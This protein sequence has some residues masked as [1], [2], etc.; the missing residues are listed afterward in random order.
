MENTIILLFASMNTEPSHAALQRYIFHV[1]Q[2]QVLISQSLKDIKPAH[3]LFVLTES[4]AVE[5]GLLNHFYKNPE[6]LVVR[7]S[8]LDQ[9]GIS[10]LDL[11]NLK[12]H[13]SMAMKDPNSIG[14]H[15]Y[16]SKE[17]ITALKPF[18]RSHG[19]NSAI[20]SLNYMKYYLQNGIRL[21]QSQDIDWTTAYNNFLSMALKSWLEYK[22]KF[23]YFRPHFELLQL[24]NQCDLLLKMNDTIDLFINGKNYFRD[25]NK[26]LKT[27]NEKLN[28][29]LHLIEMIYSSWEKISKTLQ[30]EVS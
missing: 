23:E 26:V 10:L 24:R 29:M 9:L 12:K 14:A 4:A 5:N 11:P 30:I 18:F 20:K 21:F 27:S 17:L 13:I 22:E 8:Y 3:A 7:L 16:S 2:Y 6:Q 19:E 15:F 1:F 28:D 25:K